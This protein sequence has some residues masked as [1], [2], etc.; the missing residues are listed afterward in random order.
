M[1]QIYF[2]KIL[3]I[4]F[5]CFFQTLN[6]QIFDKKYGNFF[7]SENAVDFVASGLERHS[8]VNNRLYMGVSS[9]HTFGLST[10]SK[11]LNSECF[12]ISTVVRQE[13]GESTSGYGILF[14]G[15]NISNSNL[16]L[17][18]SSKY[19]CVANYEKADFKFVKKWVYS[20]Y[21]LPKG[22]D[23]YLEIIKKENTTEFLIN[24]HIVCTIDD[25]KYYGDCFGYYLKHP[26][27]ISSERFMLETMGMN[28][29]FATPKKLLSS[30]SSDA[31]EI[32][33][34]ESDDG[35]TLYFSRISHKD[36]CGDEDDCDIWFAN[37]LGNFFSSTKHFVVPINNQYINAVIKTANNNSTVYIE[38][39]YDNN[40]MGINSNGISKITK[41]SDGYWS[42]PKSV[43]IHDFYNYNEHGTFSFSSDF[44]VLISALERKNGFG[45]LD[46]YV[47]FLNPDG[48]YSAPKNLGKIINTELDDGT[49]FIAG[50]DKMLFFSSYGHDG[51]GNS[52][53]FVTRRLDNSWLRWSKPENLG[54]E[55]NSRNWDAY[56]SVS[57]DGSSAYFVSNCNY[58]MIENIYKIDLPPNLHSVSDESLFEAQVVNEYTKQPVKAEIRYSF[59]TDVYNLATCNDGTFSLYIENHQPIKVYAKAKGYWPCVMTFSYSKYKKVRF[60]L[61]P[62]KR[63]AVISLKNI[64]FKPQSYIV[65]PKSCDELDR[66]CEVMVENPTLKILI[67]GYAVSTGGVSQVQELSECRA[68]NVKNYLIDHGI[69]ASRI[70][71]KGCGGFPVRDGLTQQALQK[72]RRVEFTVLDY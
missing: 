69:S 57:A 61:T 6:A 51:Y 4:I 21:I 32:A 47:S 33:P 66:L 11:P 67:K 71:C 27:E 17:I 16:F 55:V 34:I 41:L 58:D 62:L 46:L 70:Q 59:G 8:I 44:K 60:E 53:I 28:F 1:Y 48:S 5:I 37:K 50:D 13:S 42:N 31:S 56:F 25:L 54:P 64:E 9:D 24:G 52:D 45:K 19:F 26:V 3:I 65:D 14:S 23:N 49:P 29:V 36:N 18:S 2:C 10:I 63:G 7:T 12:K 68:E 43:K 72:Y 38:G 35:K 20:E 39:S 22:Q 40:G 15:K 30:V